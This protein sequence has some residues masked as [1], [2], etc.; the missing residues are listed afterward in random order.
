MMGKLILQPNPKFSGTVEIPCAGENPATIEF[1]FIHRTKTAL[2]E[3][4]K[5]RVGVDD[6]TSFMAMV[7]GW[8][9]AEEFNADNVEVLLQ[10]YISAA[11]ATF[12][13]YVRLLVEGKAK[14]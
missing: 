3:F 2:D 5:T 13:E 7:S 8:D 14:N 11:Q 1:T 6:V 12:Q 10:N 4:V 9:L